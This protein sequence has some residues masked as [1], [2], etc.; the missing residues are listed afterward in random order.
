MKKHADRGKRAYFQ[1][2]LRWISDKSRRSSSNKC[3]ELCQAA[4]ISERKTKAPPFRGWFLR[5]IS[6]VYDAVDR[7]CVLT[8]LQQNTGY[9]QTAAATAGHFTARLQFHSSP[10]CLISWLSPSEAINLC[11]WSSHHTYQQYNCFI[12][13]V[14]MLN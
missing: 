9:P 2:T 8:R 12:T 10:A 3:Q 14:N 11:Q 5:E 7:L 13:G 4:G 1:S 6:E